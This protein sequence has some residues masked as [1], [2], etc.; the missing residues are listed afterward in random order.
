MSLGVSVIVI[1][2]INIGAKG[3]EICYGF[4]LCLV[5]C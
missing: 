5:S 4:V 1:F 3:G 2:P